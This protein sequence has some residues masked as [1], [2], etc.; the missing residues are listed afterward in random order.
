VLIILEMDLLF[1]STLFILEFFE[2]RKVGSEN[3]VAN[4]RKSIADR[5]RRGHLVLFYDHWYDMTG[6]VEYSS[7]NDC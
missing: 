2:T 3:N 5:H 1:L 4:V 6:S 7:S